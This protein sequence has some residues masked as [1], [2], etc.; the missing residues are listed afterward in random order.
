MSNNPFNRRIY[1]LGTAST[2][3]VPDFKMEY[4]G[5]PFVPTCTIDGSSAAYQLIAKPMAPPLPGDTFICEHCF[6]SRVV[7]P[8]YYKLRKLYPNIADTSEIPNV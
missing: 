1:D 8:Q 2:R 6:I 3:D 5:I 7:D 4:L